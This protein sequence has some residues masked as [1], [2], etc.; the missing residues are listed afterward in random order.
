LRDA[1]TNLVTSVAS[2]IVLQMQFLA[3][4]FMD[5]EKDSKYLEAYCKQSDLTMK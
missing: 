2:S 5:L 3:L 4:T 1:T